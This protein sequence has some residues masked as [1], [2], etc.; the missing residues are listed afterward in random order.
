MKEPRLRLEPLAIEHAPL[1]LAYISENRGYF[2]PWEPLRSDESLTLDAQRQELAR[3]DADRAAGWCARFAGFERDGREIVGIVNL[4][5]I[6]HGVLET[7]TLGYS[8]GAR[9]CGRGYATELA[10]AV[11]RYAFRELGL[12]RVQA[13]YQPENIASERVLRKLGFVVEGY[14]RDYLFLNG[15]WR[16]AVLTSLVNPRA[17]LR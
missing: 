10:G 9:Y 15:A 8:V 16:D 17:T 13:S 4:W 1:V 6:R 7:A 11:V 2:A 12:H 5:D 3:S 14:A